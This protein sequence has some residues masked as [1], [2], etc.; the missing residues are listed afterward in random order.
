[1]D[2]RRLMNYAMVKYNYQQ[3]AAKHLVAGNL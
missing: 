2:K 3:Q 1:M